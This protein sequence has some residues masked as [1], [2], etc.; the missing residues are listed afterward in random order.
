GPGRS[1]ISSPHIHLLQ[2]NGI[3]RVN[4]IMPLYKIGIERPFGHPVQIV[5]MFQGDTYIAGMVIIGGR[6]KDLEVFI[7]THSPSIIV[8][9]A[10]WFQIGAVLSKTVY[11]HGKLHL[12]PLKV[13]FE[14]GIPNRSPD[15][16]IDTI[17]QA[18]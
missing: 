6:P 5:V 15:G 9:L 13:V 17:T 2:G 11:A 18:G 8:E 3:Y 10:H 7:I 12:F 16:V 4:L 1:G 14:G